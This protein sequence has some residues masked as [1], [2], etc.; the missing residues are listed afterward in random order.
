MVDRYQQKKYCRVCG[1]R[2]PRFYKNSGGKR[3]AVC[4]HR[5]HG[6]HLARNR[7]VCRRCSQEELAVLP[8]HNRQPWR[9]KLIHFTDLHFGHNH[10]LERM[11]VLKKWTENQGADY[12][13]ISGD[14]T[15][16]AGKAEYQRASRWLGDVG[17]TGAKVAVVPGNHDI[18]YWGNVKSLSRQAMGSKYH[19]WI[20]II[21]RPIEPCIRGPGCV[22]LGLNSAHGLSPARLMNGY[23]NR[24]QRD[25]AREILQATPAGHLKVVFCHHPLIRFTGNFHKPMHGAEKIR[26]ELA[27][28]GSDLLLWGHQ[29]S[30]AAVEL[31]Q[32]EKKCYAVQSRTLSARVREGDYPGFTVVEWFPASKVIIRAYNIKGDDTIDQYKMLQFPLGGTEGPVWNN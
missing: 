5:T 29:H 9:I 30:F 32:K 17:S 31:V 8:E 21:D 28:A 4:L 3:C 1:R 23:I 19:R 13:L 7:R 22:I 20:K 15:G 10:S 25:R 18:G 16:R 12:I 26:S 14:L 27:V 11:D 2:V 24:H 6:E